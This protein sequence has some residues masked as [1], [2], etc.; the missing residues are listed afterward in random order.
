MWHSCVVIWWYV[1]SLVV[2]WGLDGKD[3]LPYMFGDC[4]LL[5]G[6]LGSPQ[7]FLN[8]LAQVCSHCGLRVPIAAK[9]T[10]SNVQAC[11]THL[12]A[13]RL[14]RLHC[15]KQVTWSCSDS[16]KGQ[17][18]KDFLFGGAVKSHFRRT[19]KPGWGSFLVAISAN[20]RPHFLMASFPSYKLVP[21]YLQV[22]LAS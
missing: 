3:D 7:G 12:L 19:C 1:R 21:V 11:L 20:N 2:L 8:R 18:E 9:R 13:S 10:T 17:K 16:R 4:Q 15:P 14:L 5:A 22:F 6:G